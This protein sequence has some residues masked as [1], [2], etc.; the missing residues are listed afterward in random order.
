LAETVVGKAAT[1]FIRRAKDF[2]E[3]LG[4]HQDAVVGEQ[5]IRALFAEST[6]RRAAFTAGRMVERQRQQ[7]IQA[8]AAFRSN[9]KKLNK[10]GKKTWG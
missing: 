9:W 3:L 6:G 1:R 4:V 10:R 7:R 5:R 2:Q 8:R